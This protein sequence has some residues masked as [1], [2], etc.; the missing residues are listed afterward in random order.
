MQ[1][2]SIKGKPP[3]Q[4]RLSKCLAVAN[5]IL[6]TSTARPKT[7]KE[8]RYPVYWVEVF[9][10]AYQ[11]WL[12]V[13]PLVTRTVNKAQKLEPP[14]SDSANDLVYAIAFDEDGTAKDVTRRYAKAYNA[15]TRRSRIEATKD[16]QRWLRRAMR[17]Y[18]GPKQVS[19]DHETE[20]SHTNDMRRIE[21]RL[22]MP[23][24]PRKSL[25][26]QCHEMYKTSRIILIMH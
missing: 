1:Q 8:S 20:V 6:T 19:R 5:T 14:A 4:V 25:L 24:W 16:G 13:D 21:T 2:K 23:S 22:K 10:E 11:K 12:A 3:S 7:F 9:D 18:K 17:M 15:K 26:S